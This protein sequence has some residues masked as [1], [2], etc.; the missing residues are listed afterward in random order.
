MVNNITFSSRIRP[1]K[2]SE[3]IR[4]ISGY[5]ERNLVDYPWTLN[6]SVCAEKAYTKDVYDCSVCGITDGMQVLLM[7]LSPTNIA[8]FD[9]AKVLNLVKEKFSLPNKDLQ[10][11]L[12]GG[13]SGNINKP[14]S[15]QLFQK[16]EDFLSSCKIPFSKFKGGNGTS[17]VAYS[18]VTDEWI[19]ANNQME[20][21]LN[22]KT[23]STSELFKKCYNEVSIAECDDLC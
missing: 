10:A 6:Q 14:E 23:K 20:S 3:Y 9:F 11:I 5:G 4:I 8:N 12:L 7:H 18:S 22:D 15:Y 13:K 16:F 21:V 19:I 17:D 2:K 1:V